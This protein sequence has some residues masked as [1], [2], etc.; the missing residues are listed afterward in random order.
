MNEFI[1]L[2]DS[3]LIRKSQISSF[4]SLSSYVREDNFEKSHCIFRIFVTTK[5]NENIQIFILKEYT[6]DKDFSI[7]EK[8]LEKEKEIFNAFLEKIGELFEQNEKRV[9]I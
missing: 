8:R 2:N 9:E 4:Q 6:S 5:K 3:V 7:N 1:R